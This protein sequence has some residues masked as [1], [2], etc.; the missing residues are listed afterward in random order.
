MTDEEQQ[1]AGLKKCGF[2]IL[3]LKSEYYNLIR[4][5][6]WLKINLKA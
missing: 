2:R 3:E 4:T 1:N 5:K 6:K